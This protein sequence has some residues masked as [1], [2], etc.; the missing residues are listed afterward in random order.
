MGELFVNLMLHTYVAEKEPG[1]LP[2]LETF[3]EMVIGAGSSEYAFTS[4]AD[5]EAKYDDLDK[6]SMT[7][8]NYG[9]YQCKLHHAAKNIYNAG[10]KGVIQKLWKA[11]KT[12]Q[13]DMSDDVFVKMLQDEV[14]PSVSNVYLKWNKNVSEN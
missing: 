5:F 8:K 4:L 1:L 14:H 3:P 2:A 10:G 11:L 13:K 6:G 12:Y 7:A 9:W